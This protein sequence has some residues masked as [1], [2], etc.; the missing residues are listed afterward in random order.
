VPGNGL[1]GCIFLQTA[2]EASRYVPVYQYEFADPAAPPVTADPGFAMGAVHSAELPYFFPHFSNTTALDGP[3]LA[4]ESQVLANQML[5]YWTSF[6]RDG[7][8]TAPGGRE[9]RPFDSPEAV[10]RFAPGAVG[11]FDAGAEH[12]WAFWQAL[13]PEILTP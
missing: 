8:P 3:D 5:A 11:E 4:P 13:Y 9:W 7:V 6:I 1:N 10:M 12:N 2:R